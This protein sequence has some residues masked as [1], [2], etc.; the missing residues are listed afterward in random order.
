[1]IIGGGTVLTTGILHVMIFGGDGMDTIIM[2]IIPVIIMVG[3]PT[4]VGI[5]TITTPDT[6]MTVAQQRLTEVIAQALSAERDLLQTASND[7]Q[8]IVRRAQSVARLQPNAPADSLVRSVKQRLPVEA[9]APLLHQAS[10]PAETVAH[11]KDQ[12]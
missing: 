10:L 5:T 12:Q 1:M 8:Q 11:L 3:I 7:L 9:H 4:I 2:L 6:I